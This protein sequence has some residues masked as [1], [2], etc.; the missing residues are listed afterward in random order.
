MTHAT[1]LLTESGSPTLA[2]LV[3][4]ILAAQPVVDMH[5]HLYPPSFGSGGPD[6]LMLWGLDDLVTYHYL[7]AEVFRVV[8]ATILPYEQFWAM[9][10]SERADHIWKHLFVER[11]P[12]SEACRG[13]VT[14]LSALGLDPGAKSL[15]SH[16]QWFREQD[17]N[18]YID[19]VMELASSGQSKLATDLVQQHQARADILAL[20]TELLEQLA[21]ATTLQQ[22]ART[23]IYDALLI[24]RVAVGSLTLVTLMMLFL[25]VRQLQRQDRENALYEAGLVSERGKL[26]ALVK[27]RTARLTELAQHLQTVSETERSRL[28]RELHDELGG[29]LTVC[30]LEVARARR[31]TAEPPE[32]L[33]A[34][35]RIS[36]HL[37]QGIALKRRVI[38]DLRPSALTNLGLTT[39]LEN[40]TDEMRKSLG[41]TI[42]L[43]AVEIGL[44]PQ[45]ELAVYRFVQE[46]L[47]NISKYARAKRVSVRLEAVAGKAIVTVH[48]DGVGFDANAPRTGHHGLSGMQFRAE[49]MGGAMRIESTPGQGT[50]VVIEFPQA[51]KKEQTPAHT[52]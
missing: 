25:F 42:E 17:P 7:V 34:L 14:T 19:R 22:R 45:A 36:E 41:V 29:L 30:K 33:V 23:S 21:L 6:G 15:A 26:E 18:D 44:S 32:M 37:N 48:D 24:N 2:A 47:T 43:C 46:A 11:T 10:K 35:E 49:S 8:P 39:A 52:V 28:A 40:L 13:V 12:L 3:M 51:A 27:H 4:R 50:T 9:T 5:T 16:R 20:R 1:R 31:K 38:E